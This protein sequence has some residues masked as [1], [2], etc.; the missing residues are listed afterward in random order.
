MASVEVSGCCGAPVDVSAAD[1]GTCCWMCR[2]CGKPCDARPASMRQ[3]CGF[4]L[5]DDETELQRVRMRPVT[6][7]E[8]AGND[9]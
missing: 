7:A 3:P 4:A 6:E 5:D 9:W 1:E 8:E 2:E